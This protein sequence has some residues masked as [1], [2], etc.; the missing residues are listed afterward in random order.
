MSGRLKKPVP[1]R[2]SRISGLAESLRGKITAL[3]RR[4]R[5]RRITAS[6]TALVC[7]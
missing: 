6:I 7:C 1:W 3:P 2:I 4:S 5:P